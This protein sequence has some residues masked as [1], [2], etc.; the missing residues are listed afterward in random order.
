VLAAVCG[1]AAGT[2][3]GALLNRSGIVLPPPPGATGGMSLRVIHEPGAFDAPFFEHDIAAL[4]AA[5][6]DFVADASHELRTPLTA[7]RL[8]LENLEATV[9]PSGRA[10]LAA[11]LAEIERLSG[12]VESLLALARADAGGSPATPVDLAEVARERVEAWRVTAEEG[13][14]AVRLDDTRVPPVRAGR[15]RIAQV[16][17]NLLA[18]AFDA[19]PPGGAVVVGL[20][21]TGARVELR[22]RDEGHGLSAEQKARAFDRF[23]RGTSGG[24]GSGLG[25]A[26]VRRLVEADGGAI[27]LRDVAGGGL[28]AVVSLHA[29][30]SE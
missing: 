21:A 15:G 17:D 19:S 13:G 24:G 4:V 25:L 11:A 29:A 16:L 7:L 1:V 22:V 28:E 6:R 3:I 27:E 26:I 8:R 10:G 9:E 12:I 14:I 2:G 20:A 18:N 30:P 23:W 5:Q